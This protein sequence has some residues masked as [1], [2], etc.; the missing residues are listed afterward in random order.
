MLVSFSTN[1]LNF[2]WHGMNYPDSLPCRQSFMYI[3]LLLTLCCEAVM[4]IR[5][6][7]YKALGVSFCIS[8][9]FVL[10]CEKINRQ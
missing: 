1:M 9:G 10:L 7:S 2:I 6:C 8:M 3:F 4:R 5:E